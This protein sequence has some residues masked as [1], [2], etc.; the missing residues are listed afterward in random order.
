MF[1]STIHANPQLTQIMPVGRCQFERLEAI[2]DADERHVR[3]LHSQ[4]QRV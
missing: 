2:Q 3:R 1:K 4:E